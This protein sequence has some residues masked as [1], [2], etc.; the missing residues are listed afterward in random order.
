[1]AARER[2]REISTQGT[3]PRLRSWWERQRDAR[4]NP[5][6]AERRSGLLGEDKLLSARSPAVNEVSL[7]APTVRGIVT[8]PSTRFNPTRQKSMRCLA[9]GFTALPTH[10]RVWCMAM[11]R[12][13]S[14]NSIEKGS[15]RNLG[16]QRTPKRRNDEARGSRY[17]HPQ[18]RVRWQSFG[19]R[20]ARR[21]HGM[22]HSTSW[23]C[24]SN[25]FPTGTARLQL[26]GCGNCSPS[27]RKNRRQGR[28]QLPRSRT[29]GHRKSPAGMPGGSANHAQP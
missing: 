22:S 25:R 21:D 10:G 24:R 4:A 5:L 18:S 13:T 6:F 16:D 28:S 11:V 7:S 2:S 19:H 17:P 12:G 14:C 9:G 29:E 1:M 27:F 8:T 23:F 20:R 26:Q 15:N 3:V